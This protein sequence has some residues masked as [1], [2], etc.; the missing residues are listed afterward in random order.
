MLVRAMGKT[1]V[2]FCVVGAFGCAYIHA[3]GHDILG[4][5]VLTL[6]GV[7]IIAAYFLYPPAGSEKREVTKEE[8]T[9]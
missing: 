9:G 1:I 3:R 4:A 5:F 2:F 7:G 6:V 8:R